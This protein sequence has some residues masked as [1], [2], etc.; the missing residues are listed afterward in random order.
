MTINKFDRTN[1]KTIREFIEES[2]K[3]ET[4][5]NEQLNV[6]IGDLRASYTD[7]VIKFTFEVST[8]NE[9]GSVNSK[10]ASSFKAL[11][12]EYGFEPSDLG[13]EFTSLNDGKR[14]RIIGLN[15]RARKMP[16]ICER[17]EDGG[18]YKF[19]SSNIHMC[20][21]LEDKE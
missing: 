10:E 7:D 17:L 14:F 3:R 1:V 5:L 21:K 16:I 19:P 6:E 15:T 4:F 2:I 8:R 9:D 18:R 13:R 11:A 20:F 12:R